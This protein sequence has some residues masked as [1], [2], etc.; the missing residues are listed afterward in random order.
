[1]DT[2]DYVYNADEVD[3]RTISTAITPA[4]KFQVLYGD[5]LYDLTYISEYKPPFYVKWFLPTFF[6]KALLFKDR[7]FEYSRSREGADI[8]LKAYI[9]EI[10]VK[11]HN[12]VEQVRQQYQNKVKS[13][14]EEMRQSQ[15]VFPNV[16]RE[17]VLNERCFLS[18]YDDGLVYTFVVT[19]KVDFIVHERKQLCL[20]LSK[21]YVF[22]DHY[23]TLYFSRTNRL[24]HVKFY[25]SDDKH[26]SHLHIMDENR[27]CLGS[28]EDRIVNREYSDF[29]SIVA[30][31]NKIVRM[32]SEY[33]LMSCIQ[34]DPYPQ[35][36]SLLESKGKPWHQDT[37]KF[38]EEE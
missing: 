1:M 15:I 34:R 6:G 23:L 7:W 8:G 18:K 38:L 30:L 29:E 32:L 22:E 17:R 24:R 37:N 9:D 2:S 36:V 4:K 10:A 35:L 33:N 5:R 12:L 25:K 19:V 3:A 26:C 31:K 21:P 20:K 16:S 27:V 13:L 11:T 14:R 28:A